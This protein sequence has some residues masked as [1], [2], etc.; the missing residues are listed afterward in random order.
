MTYRTQ[1]NDSQRGRPCYVF[2]G[3][4]FGTSCTKVVLR[5]PY[6]QQRTFAVPFGTV[7]HDSSPYLL[8]SV[9]W[10]DNKGATSLTPIDGGFHL[11]D[12]KYHLM[13]PKPRSVPVINGSTGD[14]AFDPH[15]AAVAFLALA[16]RQVRQWFLS[17]HATTY[18]GFDLVWQVNLGLPSADYADVDLCR[19]YLRMAGAAWQLS[20]TRGLINL[21]QAEANY[22]EVKINGE[23]FSIHEGGAVD[24][25]GAGEAELR[26]VPEVA[27][28]V[29]GYARSDMR[30]EGLHLLMDVG[31][32]TLD[33]CGFILRE[34]E[35]DDR[36]D[37]L[38]TDVRNLGAMMLYRN[39]VEEIGSAIVEHADEMWD[40]CDPVSPVPEKLADYLPPQEALYRRFTL[41]NDDY[42][43]RCAKM[44]WQTLVDLKMRRDPNAPC[45]HDQVRLF[46]SGGAS[47]MQFYHQSIEKISTD[48]TRIYSPCRGIDHLSLEKPDPLEADGLADG[49]Y[50]RLAVAWGLSYPETDIGQV[51]RPAE[52]EDVAPRRVT[53]RSGLVVSKDQV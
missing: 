1:F 33:I 14:R 21:E 22:N 18:D 13:Q 37:L 50:H 40:A 11:R 52:I 2:I 34:H 24:V 28:E 27:A 8:P 5:T 44:L 31:A 51:T 25:G 16:L 20:L 43:K 42:H 32:T 7:A 53:D 4:D 23:H 26:L 39:R 10:V 6:E 49:G 35:G 3:L 9:L 45:W 46:L 47:P 30:R 41:A 15:I 19:R 38:T 36:Y 48:L 12:I 17:T 29:V